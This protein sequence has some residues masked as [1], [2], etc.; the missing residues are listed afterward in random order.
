MYTKYIRDPVW[1][2]IGIT[3]TEKSIIDTFPVQRLR[4]IKQLSVTN[5]AYPGGDHSR[6]L[7]ALGTMHLSGRIAE[8]LDLS[9][10][11]WQL[12]RLAG[13][14]HDIGHGPFSHSSE[15][16]LTKHLGVNHED[17]GERVLKE[18]SLADEVSSQG[19]SPDELAE[20]IF[21]EPGSEKYLKQII[22]SQFDADKMDFLVRDSYFTG[23][24]YG[25]I[26]VHRL[27]QA[28]R[29][30]RGD[31]AIDK[32][33][34]AALETF[35]IAR[36][37]MFLNVYY[38]H[39]VRAAEIMLREAMDHAREILGL[40]TFQDIEEFLQL[41]D[42]HIVSGLGNLEP[43]RYEGE[44]RKEAEIAEEEFEKLKRRELIKPCYE[45]EVHIS[46]EYVAKLLS[47]DS[48]RRQKELEIADKGGIDP[49]YV[50][51]DVPTLASMPYYPREIDPGEVPVFEVNVEDEVRTSPLSKIS[52]LVEVL[53][54]YI[55][56]IRVYTSPE[57]RKRVGRAAED[58]FKQL[59][60]SAQVSM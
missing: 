9:E 27:I 6:F 36:Y 7:H 15:E 34:L 14:L 41:D 5:I 39:S 2:Y 20:L 55:D 10:D 52:R 45:R 44:K 24:E 56:L 17:L 48:V 58:V 43:S 40:T 3:E 1:G 37:E 46:D 54:G 22:A 11:D 31:I 23:V 16:I 50:T 42:A 35:M 49:E 29:I 25:Q 47:D 12:V 18:S 8:N 53:R 51:V 57:H 19:F 21:G 59:P 33:A 30:I 26:D 28:M 38:H 4:G 32:K 60:L 13:L